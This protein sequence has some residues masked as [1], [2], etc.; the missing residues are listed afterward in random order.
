MVFVGMVL[1]LLSLY[2]LAQNT[3]YFDTNKT[4]SEKFVIAFT[5]LSTSLKNACRSGEVIFKISGQ[6]ASWICLSF[7]LGFFKIHKIQ[8]VWILLGCLVVIG[9]PGCYLLVSQTCSMLVNVYYMHW[10]IIMNLHM[11]T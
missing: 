4:V 7:M 10:C 9:W 6:V 5:M 2:F 8:I 3:I 1:W 11:C